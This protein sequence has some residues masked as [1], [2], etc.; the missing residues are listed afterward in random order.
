MSEAL[1]ASFALAGERIGTVWVIT[2]DDNWKFD[3]EDAR[4]LES[5]A[6]FASAA[7]QVLLS[8]QAA[9]EADRGKDEFLAILSHELRSPLSSISMWIQTLLS[10]D[11]DQARRRQALVAIERASKLQARMVDDLMDSSSMVAAKL[12]VE[13]EPTDLSLIVTRA[14]DTAG[15]AASERRL[16]PSASLTRTL[17]RCG[18][19]RA[20]SRSSEP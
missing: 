14:V 7:Y 16:T 8:L 11:L 3:S 20:S 5:L 18:I 12:S 19:R 2:H 9:K 15:D 6:H 10:R 13:L 4:V 1:L 17:F